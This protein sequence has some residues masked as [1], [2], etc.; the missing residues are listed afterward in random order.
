MNKKIITLFVFGF[1]LVSMVNM[2]S[3]YTWGTI[4]QNEELNII[5][6]CPLPNCGNTTITSIVYPNSLI[7][8]SDVEA[9][10]IGSQWNYT[11]TKTDQL[12]IYKVYGYSI[13]IAVDGE[14]KEYFI[15]DFEV[16]STGTDKFDY[17]FIIIGLTLA[18]I[19]LAF[20]LVT[21]EELFVYIS[22]LFFLIVGIF[23]MIN[24]FAYMNN[25]TTR[26][27]AYICLGLGMLFTIGAYIFNLYSSNKHQE[28]EF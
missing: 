20:S 19:F 3:A 7:A 22:G 17:W 5:M 27:L 6:V 2:V 11:F 4:K 1:I 21:P 28:E 26:M 23:I 13:G 10:H 24:G 9:T 18:V 12:G 16:T 25:D 8:I 14:V 15:G